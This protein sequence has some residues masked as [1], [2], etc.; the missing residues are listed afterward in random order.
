MRT[1]K[2]DKGTLRIVAVETSVLQSCRRRMQRNVMK[3]R[4]NIVFFQ[5]ADQSCSLLKAVCHDVEH[6]SVVNRAFWNCRDF[7]FSRN[8]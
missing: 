6:V 2:D 1:S 7:N 8:S 4:H 5:V 3:Y